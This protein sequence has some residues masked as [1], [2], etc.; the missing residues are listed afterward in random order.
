MESFYVRGSDMSAICG[1]NIYQP[2]DIKL[3]KKIHGYNN[4]IYKN[5]CE[6]NNEYLN[7][8]IVEYSKEKGLLTEI[9][10]DIE[11]ITEEDKQI[12]I[13][14][15]S[16]MRGNK[17]ELGDLQK[18]VNEKNKVK[19]VI[20]NGTD[21]K[22]TTI[23]N[24]NEKV[25]TMVVCNIRIRSKIDGI[26]FEDDIPT[27]LIET[28][29]RRNRLFYSIPEYEKVQ[30]EVY[31]RTIHLTIAT[32]IENFKDENNIIEYERDDEFWNEITDGVDIFIEKYTE[33][34]K[35]L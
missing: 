30:L 21:Y 16:I 10:A 25:Y 26:E 4:G 19:K 12:I 8:K 2:V 28:K 13:E 27:N 33:Y 11:N 24:N 5:I 32:H 18:Y 29:R 6:T 14:K 22:K 34:V 1:K 15:A 35:N 3:F 20:S 9:M 17:H 23:R 7:K 31:L